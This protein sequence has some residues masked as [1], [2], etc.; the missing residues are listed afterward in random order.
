MGAISLFTT[1]RVVIA[2]YN[3][4]CPNAFNVVFDK[5]PTGEY[6]TAEVMQQ[7][8]NNASMHLLLSIQENMLY[9][10]PDNEIELS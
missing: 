2:S 9:W 3:E 1:V 6:L 10:R 4:P 5:K 8:K 7:A